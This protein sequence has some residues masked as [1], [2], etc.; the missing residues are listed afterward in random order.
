VQLLNFR[1]QYYL[2]V[3]SQFGPATGSRWYNANE[4]A[5]FSAPP[6][7]A[8]P[9]LLG[10][11]GAE[12]II[13]YWVTDN[14]KIVFNSVTMDQPVS[15]TAVYVLTYSVQTFAVIAAVLAAFVVLIIVIRKRGEKA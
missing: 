5:A 4:T 11:V 2:T 1:T 9:G 6:R 13:V 7:V 12:Y 8:A 10:F 14:G 3:N 15:V